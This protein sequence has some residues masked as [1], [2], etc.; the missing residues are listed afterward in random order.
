MSTTK[1]TLERRIEND[2]YACEMPEL[3]KGD[4]FRLWEP[5]GELVGDLNYVA[6]SKP[7]VWEEYNGIPI[8]GIIANPEG[9][10]NENQ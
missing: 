4:V 6:D 10:T 1:R 5:T 2:W 7:I 3:N 8:W 9:E